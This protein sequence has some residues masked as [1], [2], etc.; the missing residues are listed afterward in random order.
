MSDEEPGAVKKTIRTV[1]PY[2][3]G[4]PDTE[5]TT[6]G[7]VYFLGLV[8]LLVPLLPFLLIVWLV[9]KLTGRA[10]RQSPVGGEE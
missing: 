4:R 1:T 10:A 7:I 5:M 3:R 2:Y 6:I 8:V 9:S